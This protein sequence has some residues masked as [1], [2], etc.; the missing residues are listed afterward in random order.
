MNYRKKC[1]LKNA[2]LTENKIRKKVLSMNVK[3]K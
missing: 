1:F 3:K 2:D